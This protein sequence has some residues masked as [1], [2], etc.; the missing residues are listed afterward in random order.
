MRNQKAVEERCSSGVSV[1]Y[2]V[3]NQCITCSDRRICYSY[4]CCTPHQNPGSTQNG[5]AHVATNKN[6][7]FV[8]RCYLR[9]FTIGE[10]HAAI[11][12]Y[13]LERKKL[14]L[15][16]PVKNQCSRDYFYG[17]DE[18]LECAIQLVESGYGAVLRKILNSSK[19]LLESDKTVLRIFWLFQ[20]LR[21]EAA[22]VRA[23]EMTETA[24][25]ISGINNGNFRVGIK[26]AVMMAVKTFADSMRVIDD[27]KFCLIKNETKYPFITSDNPAVLTNKWHLEDRRTRVQSFG[28]QSAGA[29]TMLPLSP[30]LL[31]LGYDGNVYSV[32]HSDG[33]VSVKNEQDIMAFNQHQ[34]LNCR[35]NVFLKDAGQALIVH[36]AHS[37]IEDIRPMARH[38]IHYA[39][40][41]RTEGNFTRYLVTNL[42]ERNKHDDALLHIQ[43]IHPKPTRWP[44]QIRTREKGSVFT[45]G[46]GMGYVR[47]SATSAYADPPFHSERASFGEI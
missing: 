20:Y 36:R 38:I 25:E 47:H 10:T 37:E 1:S 2:V 40:R 9:P 5:I 34:F 45:N 39:V 18:K 22:A 30:K 4:C 43:V 35:V 33:V 21:T 27:L 42:G 46:S 12:L 23:V 7:H 41:G 19:I 15:M 44:R 13:N 6:Q 28:L 32:P 8:P 24:A 16:A 11:N 26:E 3:R 17:Q 31:L 29:L 14:I